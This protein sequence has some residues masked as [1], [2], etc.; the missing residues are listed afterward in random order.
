LWAQVA[1][2][3]TT[4]FVSLYEK[5]KWDYR[6]LETL[7]CWGTDRNKCPNTK[8]FG[9][10]RNTVET[11]AQCK[12]KAEALVADRFDDI[13]LLADVP[14][15]LLADPDESAVDVAGSL[16]HA[17]CGRQCN[18]RNNQQVLDQSLATLVVVKALQQS[19]HSHHVL[20]LSFKIETAWIAKYDNKK[21]SRPDLV[22]GLRRPPHNR[23]ADDAAF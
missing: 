12:L 23:W 19:K 18:K 22:W 15:E 16:S 14:T 20:L 7:T 5:E 9:A 11:V 1:E 3:P 8:S 21:S 2:G 13:S 10:F 4:H 6:R 17:G